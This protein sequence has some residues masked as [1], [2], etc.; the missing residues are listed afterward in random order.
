MDIG[1]GYGPKLPA[2]PRETKATGILRKVYTRNQSSILHHIGNQVQH[3]VDKLRSRLILL[4]KQWKE[5]ILQAFL[6]RHFGYQVM[7]LVHQV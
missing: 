2:A 5:L 4:R 3:V 7:S 1:H 6:L